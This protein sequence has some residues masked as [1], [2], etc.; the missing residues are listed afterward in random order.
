MD[1]F[2][3]EDKDRVYYEAKATQIKRFADL[4]KIDMYWY[5][6][7][8]NIYDMLLNILPGA[9]VHSFEVIS[10]IWCKD[11]EHV[12]NY[13]R[14]LKGVDV[15]S[16]RPISEITPNNRSL[17][18]TFGKDSKNV[19]WREGADVESFEIVEF[20][21]PAGWT[22][23]DRNRIYSGKDSPALQEYLK[24]KYGANK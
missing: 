19:F 20:P 8:K 10:S 11:K 9:D 5:S 24:S 23:F 1:Y 2:I 21:H 17:S 3:G 15:R 13:T 12:W 14:P 22:V 18:R 16:F 4:T 6:D 7:G